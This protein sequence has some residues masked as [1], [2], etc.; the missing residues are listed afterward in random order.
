M[1]VYRFGE[2][3]LDLDAFE[4]KRP[5]KPVKLERRALDLLA[6]LVRQPN[7]LVPREELIAALW[8]PN[9]VIDF[10]SGLNT[11]V[12]K[13]RVALG[14]SSESPRFI[15]TV[16]GRGYRFVSP[17]EVVT[18]PP[19]STDSPTPAIV[20]SR[21]RVWPVFAAV[22]ALVALA[23][24]AMWWRS[25]RAPAGPVRI[26]V[27]PFE[28]LTGDAEYAYLAAGLA[29]DTSILLGNIDV[30]NLRVIA[31][32]ARGP[33]EP[34]PSIDEIGRRLSLDYLVQSSLQ[35]EGQK[36]RVAS[37]L[38]RVADAEQVW[39]ASIDRELLSALE[40]QRE[41]STAIAEQVRMRL[42]PAYAAAIAQRQ[43]QS[44]AAYALYLKGRYEW[45]KLTP[46]S[47]R[48]ALEYFEQA[49]RTDPN[50]ALAWAGLAWGALTSVRTA[51][52]SPAIAAPIGRKA[53]EQAVRLGPDLV[54]TKIAQ[55][56][57]NFF[58]ELDYV[59]AE[60]IARSAIAQ[61]PNNSVAH[62]L[63]GL[64]LMRD[65]RL[66]AREMLRRARELEPMNALVFANS[67]NVALSRGDLKEGLELARQTVAVDPEFWL[68]HFYLGR[69]LAALGDP[70]AALH[71]Y[72]E[73]ARLSDGH[74][75]TYAARLSMLL[76]L[77][78][79]DEARAVLADAQTR[80]A[81]QYMPPYTLATMYAQLDETDA[82]FE[83]LERAIEVRDMNLLG[84][85]GD[86]Q[87]QSLRSDPR[88]ADIVQRCGC[89][90]QEGKA[91]AKP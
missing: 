19:P 40:V 87:L 42:S 67:V 45:N 69:S 26:A 21:R 63:L 27:L 29:E 88:F 46:A 4:L 10:D 70:S 91:V 30:A 61:D 68:G 81:R 56:Y 60:K 6:L 28:N 59:A 41:L 7:R 36:I 57:L 8:P 15:D 1:Q 13:V 47:T 35:L 51:D 43:T 82:A 17:V 73:A 89:T 18:K 49:T 66:E 76:R 79:R 12:R 2:F 37:R 34:A 33:Q 75:L 90:P 14:D 65:D 32:P 77:G 80:A 31:V 86:P 58:H 44:P 9:V 3:E 24:G 83:S 16:P 38:L 48:R 78:R 20:A 39:S 50:Y 64:T 85:M 71:E 52:V 53:L 54:E 55:G 72:S 22:L 74:S 23:L 11:L 62:M 5:G 25:A 84:L